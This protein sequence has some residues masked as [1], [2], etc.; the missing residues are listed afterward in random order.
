MKKMRSLVDETCSC[1]S[2]VMRI[3]NES[4]AIF[5]RDTKGTFRCRG[6]VRIC[7]WGTLGWG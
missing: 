1:C 7:S 2:N 6:E 4:V 3:M 5:V